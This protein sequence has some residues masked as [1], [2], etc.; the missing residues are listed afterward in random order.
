MGIN[1]TLAMGSGLLEGIQQAMV[2]NQRKEVA[3]L[4]RDF[5]DKQFKLKEKLAID[6]AKSQTAN[7]K[8]LADYVEKFEQKNTPTHVDS[9]GQGTSMGSPDMGGQAAGPGGQAGGFDP[10]MLQ[11]PM[12]LLLSKNA[13]NDVTQ[14]GSLMQRTDRAGQL[15][16]E[17]VAR[18]DESKKKRLQE[19]SKVT[20][21]TEIN[22]QTGEKFSVPRPTYPG[23]QGQGG[24]LGQPSQAVQGGDNRI[25]TGRS[26]GQQPITPQDSPFV[27]HPET[28]DRAKPNDK[29][30]DWYNEQGYIKVAPTQIEKVQKLES[31][32]KII[33]EVEKLMD[34]NIP[35]DER[36]AAGRLGAVSRAIESKTQF[37]QTGVE[38]AVMK[39]YIDGNKAQV[40]KA[41]GEVGNLSE[42]EQQ[43]VIS[44]F[45]DLKD[46][47]SKHWMQFDLLKKTFDNAKLTSFGRGM[48]ESDEFSPLPKRAYMQLE[49]GKETTFG[50]GQTWTINHGKVKRVK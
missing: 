30:W 21:V 12:Y 2:Y 36:G 4:E 19:G 41:L 27:I 1:K 17:S 38:L 16:D 48:A 9:M 25:Q 49:E 26:K 50:N 47:G 46:V 22:P 3:Q 13:G 7:E 39:D 31:V 14:I 20:Y 29:S 23:A 18:L 43:A 15:H 42:Q 44:L 35:R 24:G 32:Q 5:K 34:K 37:T 33:A 10:K 45:G 28:Y 6:K 40:A 8:L 11:D